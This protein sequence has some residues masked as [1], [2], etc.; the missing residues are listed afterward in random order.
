MRKH[1][2]AL[3]EKHA[4]VRTRVALITSISVTVLAAVVWLTTLPVRFASLSQENA[5]STSMAAVI[6]A[7]GEDTSSPGYVQTDAATGL[8]ISNNPYASSESAPQT[9]V[10]EEAYPATDY[11]NY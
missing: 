4:S 5:T 3:R 9:A 2:T 8:E 6:G 1:L 11:G 10:P 7:M